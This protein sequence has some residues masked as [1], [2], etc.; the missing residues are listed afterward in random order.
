LLVASLRL[1][2]RLVK[3]VAVCLL[4]V[5]SC[6]FLQTSD[7]QP[8]FTTVIASPASAGRS[9][10]IGGY[11]LPDEPELLDD[12]EL[13]LLLP[14]ELPEDAWAELRLGDDDLAAEELTEPRLGDD[15]LAA[16]AD[17]LDE[18]TEP[19]LL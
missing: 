17:D 7:S 6:W 18:D 8:I 1:K 5:T 11:L 16:G 3:L 12:P 10:L 2:L 19:D 14:D 4:L 15:D 13:L 9:N